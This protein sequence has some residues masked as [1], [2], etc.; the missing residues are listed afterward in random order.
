MSKRDKLSGISAGLGEV[1]DKIA[2]PDGNGRPPRTAPGQLMA[3]RNEAMAYEDRIAALENELAD[4]KR[5]EIPV[6]L[7]A[8]NPWQ[9]RTY[10]NSNEIA[11][12]AASI[13]EIGLV[14]PVIVRRVQTL[15]TRPS[16]GESVQTLDTRYELI[17]GERRLRAHKE[18]G[19]HTIKAIVT[20][21]ADDDMAM[22]ALAENLD[23]ADLSDYEISK[24]IRRAEREFPSRKHMAKALG[25]ERSDL[26]RYL[27]FDNL[28]EFIRE[29]LEANPRLLGRSA[30]DQVASLLK[31]GGSQVAV[32]ISAIWQKVKDGHID[33][34]KMASAIQS[35]IAG[36]ASRTDRDIRKLFIGKDQAGSITKDASALTVKIKS[37]AL[38]AQKENRLR[39]FVQK[40]LVEPD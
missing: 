38:S 37:A 18:L 28:P 34:T 32:A 10:F 2:A 30:A 27:A 15:D 40:L 12:L 5:T 25:L 19:L 8:P 35:S 9:P 14:Q 17:A 13:S 4:A 36:K 23:R 21:A 16:S 3:F 22:M 6:D 26:Y 29:D 24:A 11:D 31:S 39:E 1:L 20:T 7:I 33:E